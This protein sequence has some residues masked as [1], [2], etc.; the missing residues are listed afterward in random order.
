MNLLD[1]PDMPESI[2]HDIP[3]HQV[4]LAFNS[5]DDADKFRDWWREAGWEMFKAWASSGGE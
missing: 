3:D 4:L 2:R 5:D 1:E